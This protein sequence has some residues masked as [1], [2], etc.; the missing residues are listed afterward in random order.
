MGLRELMCFSEEMARPYVA[1]TVLALG[2]LHKKGIVHRDLKPDN[3]LID[4]EGHIKLTDFGLSRV[5]LLDRQEDNQD[6]KLRR[7]F[8]KDGTDR[9][10]AAEQTA[11]GT[12]DYI[13]PEVFLGTACGPEVDWW[14]LGCILYEFLIGITPF[15]GDDLQEIFQNILNQ[16]TSS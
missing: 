12:P 13:A 16:G 4:S 8:M 3:I 9:E 14:A 7:A 5:G 10:E 11:A 15:Y 1:E 2:Y 6:W